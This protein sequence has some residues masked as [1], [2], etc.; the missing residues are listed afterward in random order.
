M[1]EALL[2][3]Y[4]VAEKLLREM[5]ANHQR[6]T[7]ADAVREAARRGVSRRTLTKARTGIGATEIHNGPHPAFWQAPPI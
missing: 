5:F 2:T 4:E 1:D 6:I 7:I 3:K